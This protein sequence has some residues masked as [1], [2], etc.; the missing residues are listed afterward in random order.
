[1]PIP[2]YKPSLVYS[3]TYA[4]AI[5]PQ[6]VAAAGNPVGG[7]VSVALMKWAKVI[8]IAG[9]GAGTVALKL[10]QATSSGGAGAKDLATAAVLGI[11][12]QANSTEVQVDF[13]I[14]EN[15]DITNAF[16]FIRLNATVTGGAGTLYAASLELGP[17][18]FE[19]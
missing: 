14:P 5:A 2:N 11:T 4:S 10:E 6:S 8:S 7:W 15:I 17:Q 3:G 13:D 19:G 16:A 9:A 12:A 1:M 18:S